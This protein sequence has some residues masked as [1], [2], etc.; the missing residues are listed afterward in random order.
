[1]RLGNCAGCYQVRALVRP[2]CF[3]ASR[4]AKA[5]PQSS[6]H[7]VSRRLSGASVRAQAMGTTENGNRPTHLMDS[8][9]DQAKL[10]VRSWHPSHLL[11]SVAPSCH[12][13]SLVM[14]V[15]TTLHRLLPP[16]RGVSPFPHGA[17]RQ[18]TLH[19]SRCKGL[20]WCMHDGN[21]S[22]SLKITQ[23][24]A[25]DVADVRVPAAEGGP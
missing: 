12:V 23:L 19:M 6:K 18:C 13:K 20:A 16:C 4:G 7:P 10:Q 14:H 15:P 2:G 9:W 3:S 25:G 5:A 22:F 17:W 1:M 8:V 21:C 24:H 11:S